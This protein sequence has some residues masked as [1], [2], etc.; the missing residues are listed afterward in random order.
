MH[1]R[2]QITSFSDGWGYF[3][4]FFIGIRSHH[5]CTLAP[6]P[7]LSRLDPLQWQFHRLFSQGQK[8]NSDVIYI[9]NLM[10]I[11]LGHSTLIFP[12]LVRTMCLFTD[13]NIDIASI[14]SEKQ[15]RL[16]V[17]LHVWPS[18]SPAEGSDVESFS[19][20]W[21]G[22]TGRRDKELLAMPVGH[23]VDGIRFSGTCAS[24]DLWIL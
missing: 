9:D 6:K 11:T 2:E 8:S 17:F 15:I 18:L 14:W 4:H 7:R 13:G 12:P 1:G 10:S 16:F 21:N 5:S 23:L 22:S 20:C 3:A 19:N 24:F